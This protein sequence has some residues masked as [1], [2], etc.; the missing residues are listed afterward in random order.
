MFN[1][2][3]FND[4]IKNSKQNN[5]QD[6]NYDAFFNEFDSKSKKRPIENNKINDNLNF[7]FS[8]VS[9]QQN[10]QQMP[11][12]FN[13]VQSKPPVKKDDPFNFDDLLSGNKQQAK[14]SKKPKK[15]DLED[16]LNF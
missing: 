12:L 9:R 6:V 11:N 15:N 5:K 16:L 2:L 1:E 14:D 13:N 4:N 7:D 8:N 3:N 10:K